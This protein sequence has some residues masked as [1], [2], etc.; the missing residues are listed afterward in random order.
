MDGDDAGTENILKDFTER[1][2]DDDDHLEKYQNT[3]NEDITL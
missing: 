2:V 3:F 1:I